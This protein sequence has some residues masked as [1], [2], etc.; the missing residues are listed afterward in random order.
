MEKNELPQQDPL[1]AIPI[2]SEYTEAKEDNKGLIQLMMVPP[3][4]KGFKGLIERKLR[5]IKPVRVN[6]DERGTFFWKL[7]DGERTL[8]KIRKK[9]NKHYNLKKDESQEA[10]IAFVK[11]LMVRNLIMLKLPQN[12]AGEKD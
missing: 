11:M 8:E 2:V 9:L 7:I 1:K 3:P 6:L 12:S 4:A 5:L 10:V